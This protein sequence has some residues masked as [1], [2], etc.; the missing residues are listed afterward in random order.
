MRRKQKLTLEGLEQQ[1]GNISDVPCAIDSKDIEALG[2][3]P[4]QATG[5][6]SPIS[7]LAERLGCVCSGP[8]CGSRPALDYF[9]FERP[10]PHV[11]WAN[12]VLML[13]KAEDIEARRGELE[14]WLTDRQMDYRATAHAAI[15]VLQFAFDDAEMAAGFWNACGGT[16]LGP[17]EADRIVGQPGAASEDWFVELARV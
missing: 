2:L 14:R 15:A 13:V 10:R 12:R 3:W 8:Y 16:L 7:A 4:V 17:K 9:L 6:Q 5:E 11:P 1:L